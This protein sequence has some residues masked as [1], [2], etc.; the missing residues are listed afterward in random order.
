LAAP[1]KLRVN[2]VPLLRTPLLEKD[3]EQRLV[4]LLPILKQAVH[5]FRVYFIHALLYSRFLHQ[6]LYFRM[7]LTVVYCFAAFSER[8][9]FVGY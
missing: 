7:Q 2:T 3:Y 5:S 4:L 6:F 1:I 8:A 9:L